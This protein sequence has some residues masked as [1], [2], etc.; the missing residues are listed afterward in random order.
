MNKGELKAETHFT[1]YEI[2]GV[3]Q[4]NTGK[5]HNFCTMEMQQN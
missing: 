2:R 3:F 4:L 1:K 5:M